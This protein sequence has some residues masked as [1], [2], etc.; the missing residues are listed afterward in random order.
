MRPSQ[1]VSSLRRIAVNL[2]GS[3]EPDPAFVR[4]DLLRLLSSLKKTG[5]DQGQLTQADPQEMIPF[6][7]VDEMYE[8]IVEMGHRQ[9]EFGT[10]DESAA[11]DNYIWTYMGEGPESLAPENLQQAQKTF[12]EAFQRYKSGV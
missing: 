10:Q 7:S 8:N 4:R 6:Q 2:Q 5:I 11:F 9:A 12:S 1:V 3:R